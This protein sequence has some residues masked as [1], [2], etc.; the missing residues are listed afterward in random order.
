MA[1]S[2]SSTDLPEEVQ[3]YNRLCQSLIEEAQ[4][5]MKY[6]ERAGLEKDDEAKG[7]LKHAQSEEYRHF[8]M[9]LEALMRLDPDWRAAGEDIL[10]RQG[11]ITEPAEDDGEDEDEGDESKSSTDPEGS[12][13][14]EPVEPAAHPRPGWSLE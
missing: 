8:C 10:F 13:R 9:Q 3:R 12:E 14:Q 2:K 11:P 5:I 7:V 4:A 6:N 1:D